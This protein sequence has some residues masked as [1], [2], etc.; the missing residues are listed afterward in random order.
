MATEIFGLIESQHHKK[1]H[2]LNRRENKIREV[3]REIKS[4]IKRFK[5]ASTEEKQPLSV[6]RD[7]LRGK[8]KN[9]RRVEWHRGGGKKGRGSEPL[10]Y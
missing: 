1:T 8:L 5:E 9:N 2:N 4:L 10:S 6:L 3:R 7:F